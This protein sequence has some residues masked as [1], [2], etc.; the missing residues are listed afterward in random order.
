MEEE[1]GQAGV[2]ALH[3]LKIEI[4]LQTK[5]TLVSFGLISKEI[6]LLRADQDNIKEELM[7]DRISKNDEL[8]KLRRAL[9]NLK[10]FFSQESKL[11]LIGNVNVYLL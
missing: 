3:Y 6:A 9:K 4:N 11:V 5:A 8:L 7:T 1:L 10:V 2:W